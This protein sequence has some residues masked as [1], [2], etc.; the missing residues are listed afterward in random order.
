MLQ[1]GPIQGYLNLK[2]GQP[3]IL[4]AGVFRYVKITFFTIYDKMSQ[5]FTWIEINSAK[6]TLQPFWRDEFIKLNQE[7][8]IIF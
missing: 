2:I 8:M 5:A 4:K 7:I 6:N 1:V 3:P